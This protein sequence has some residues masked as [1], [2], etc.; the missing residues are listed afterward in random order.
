[1][2]TAT[3]AITLFQN[4][5]RVVQKREHFVTNE[6]LERDLKQALDT[7]ADATPFL[8]VLLVSLADAEV[9]VEGVTLTDRRT[10]LGPGTPAPFA[11]TRKPRLSR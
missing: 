9:E 4:G 3:V 11:A 5:I 1:M 8:S 6:A 10:E 7:Q 2:A